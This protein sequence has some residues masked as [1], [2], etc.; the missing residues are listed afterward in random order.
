MKKKKGYT[1]PQ[2]ENKQKEMHIKVL[3]SA[4]VVTLIVLL[5]A[6]TIQ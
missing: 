1:P 6:I 4:I 2:G 3:I 5:I